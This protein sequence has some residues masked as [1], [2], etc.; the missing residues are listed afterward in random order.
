MYGCMASPL[1]V[2]VSVRFDDLSMEPADGSLFQSR[3][4]RGEENW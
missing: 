4:V 1:E 3:M 2:H